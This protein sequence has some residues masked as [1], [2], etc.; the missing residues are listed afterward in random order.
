MLSILILINSIIAYAQSGAGTPFK[1]ISSCE[2]DLNGDSLPD[3]AQL[4]ESIRGRE[5][6]VLL[7]IN[8][9]YSAYLISQNVPDGMFLS[10]HF[11]NNIKET[12]AGDDRHDAQ[13]YK[14]PGSYLKLYYPEGSSLGYFWNGKEFEQVW[15][16]D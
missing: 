12:T 14:T 2:I 11:G 9:G 10:C 5:L 8:D 6:I 4:I 7:R 16:S 13:T 15:L 1:Y 3:I